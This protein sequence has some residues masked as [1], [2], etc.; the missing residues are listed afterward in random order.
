MNATTSSIVSEGG[1]AALYRQFRTPAHLLALTLLGIFAYS[2]TFH[3]P[4]IFDDMSSIVDNPVIRDLSRFLSGEGRA[5]N[6][7]RV[8]GYFTFALNYRLGGLDTLGYHLVNISVHILSAWM[9]Y[10]LVRLTLRTPYFGTRRPSDLLSLVPLFAALL[11]VSHP[12]QTQAVTYIVQR[13]A[14]LVTLFY[15][16][17]LCCYVK[18]RFALLAA[19]AAGAKAEGGASSQ[20]GRLLRA[21]LFFAGALFFALLAIQTKEVAAT[22]PVAVLLYE[23]C[24]FEPSRKRNLILAAGML[25]FAL[26]VTVAVLKAGKPLGELLSDVNELSRETTTISRGD[27]LLTE[28]SVIATYLRLLFL[29]VNQNLDYDYPV[30]HSLFAPQVLLSF[31]LLAGLFALAL[32]RQRASSRYG[33]AKAGSARDEQLV[34][35]HC[36]RLMA[37]GIFW[38]FLTL[39]VESSVIPI[40]D[41]IFEHRLYL[42]TVGAFTALASATVF[43]FRKASAQIV[44][45]AIS[46]IAL[47]LGGVT[48]QRNTRWETPV[49]LWS[50]VVA[51]SPDKS[52]ANDHYGVALIGAGRTGEAMEYLKAALQINPRNEFALYNLGRLFDETNDTVAAVSCYQAAIALKP[53]LEVAYNNLAVDYLLQGDDDRA[54]ECYRIVL[55]HKPRFAEAHNNLGYALQRKGKADE[56]I[57]HYQAALKANPGYAKAYNNLGEAYC[58]KG[59]WDLAIAQFQEA[60]RL[61][62]EDAAARE[63]LA[64]AL[65]MKKGRGGRGDGQGA[66]RPD[67]SS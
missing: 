6:P 36:G 43:I 7:R 2:N 42:P 45:V 16:L 60:L 46:V 67:R 62:P 33:F 26:V 12:V 50:D 52:R 9:V 37:F 65:Q 15:L 30:Y 41:V 3:S 51:K 25:L 39:S 21:A 23:Y 17:A 40:S 18:G 53:D 8:V 57:E 13:L 58:G 31:L 64:R 48:W 61:K 32:W 35:A 34:T 19:A 27:Y 56:A 4:F 10:F 22:L 29:P 59:E 55:K 66:F 28:F 14:S 24:F 49:T 38:F 11:F 63:N 54:I 20:A 44:A 1:C 5:F 47:I